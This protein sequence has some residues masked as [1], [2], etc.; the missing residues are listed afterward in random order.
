MRRALVT[1]ALSLCLLA[2]P[3][4]G[5]EADPAKR[6]LVVERVELTAKP[7]SEKDAASDLVEDA[8]KPRTQRVVV[9][10]YL[11][12]S[13]GDPLRPEDLPAGR[14]R[15][16]ETGFYKSVD[17]FARPGSVKGLVVVVVELD[18][19]V[20]P[21]YRFEGGHGELDGWYIVPVGFVYDNP[22]G[23]GHELDLKWYVGS[24]RDGHRW[25]YGHP[26]LFSGAAT[27]DLYWYSE[28]LSY[29]QWMNGTRTGEHV[30]ADGVSLR[31]DGLTGSVRH[32][33]TEVRTARYNP[34][35]DE[36]LAAV[37]RSD[38]RSAR[39]TMLSVGWQKD[40]RDSPRFP[41]A[42]FWGFTS[43]TQS[44]GASLGDVVFTRL[45]LEGRWYHRL[46]S[47]R[48]AA[49]RIK[50]G[51]ATEGAP[52]YQRY[53]LGGPY[54]HRRFDRAEATPV[55]WGTRTLQVQS[56]LRLPFGRWDEAGPRNTA[57]V[58]YD[59]GG[60]WGPGEIPVPTDLEHA[61]GVG[62]RRSVRVLGV[63]RLDLSLP[64]IPTGEASYW[65]ATHLWLTLG[66]AF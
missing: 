8:G 52:F 34:D 1:S 2:P 56:E 50:S 6:Q 38:L 22:W 47:G 59:G 18:E 39:L 12:L 14:Q 44:L 45:D 16:Q 49:V 37:L 27:L 43:L 63:L 28:E 5:Q 36:G 31:V 46:Q 13:A 65:E 7:P 60:I 11:G 29:P 3:L 17:V 35:E 66:Q 64:L 40:S 61:M 9:E 55:G 33:F 30:S 20:Q 53:Y 51:L 15:L 42:G 23:R 24:D 54:S 10:R 25:H 21:Q 32:L 57:V 48:V 62:Y 19:H 58:F 26:R 4:Q 41:T